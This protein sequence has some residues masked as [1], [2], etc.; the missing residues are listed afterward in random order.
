MTKYRGTDVEV[1]MATSLSGLTT[2]TAIPNIS[3][4]TWKVSQG[5]TQEPSGFGSRATVTK[6]GVVKITGTIK[7][8]YDET[9]ID[10]TNTFQ[11]EGNAFETT[12][13][14]R[15]VL[16]VKNVSTGDKYQFTNVVGDYDQNAPSVDGIM[17]DT[18]TWSADTVAKTT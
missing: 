7:R 4:V 15:H 14:T 3:T 5:I 18:F 17:V 13:L 6:E 16:E 8:D 1:R 9:K 11:Q 12:S 10:G 2:A